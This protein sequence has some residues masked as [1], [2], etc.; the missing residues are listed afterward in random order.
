[1]TTKRKVLMPRESG[2]IIS[3]SSTSV[4]IENEGILKLA[5]EVSS[6]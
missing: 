2:Q 3:Q 1:M 6:F 5:K 4:F